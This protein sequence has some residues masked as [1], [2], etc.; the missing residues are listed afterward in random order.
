MRGAARC[1]RRAVRRGRW[2]RGR[3]CGRAGPPWVDA[4][5]GG[6]LPVLPHCVAMGDW[7]VATYWGTGPR[8]NPT[9]RRRT[10]RWAARIGW[11]APGLWQLDAVQR[12]GFPVPEFVDQPQVLGV[13]AAY[14]VIMEL[15]RGPLL[16]GFN[17]VMAHPAPGSP[18]SARGAPPADRRVL[19]RAADLIGP[20]QSGVI[21]AG[22]HPVLCLDRP[23]RLTGSGPYWRIGRDD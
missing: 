11:A 4:A 10:D 7:A 5:P 9:V 2:S 21:D 12:Y 8:P 14:D 23:V 6:G 1:R 13:V 18:R 15:G 20:G 19:E 3:W 17:Y 22:R 16:P